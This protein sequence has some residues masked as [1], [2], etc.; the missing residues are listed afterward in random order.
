MRIILFHLRC[1]TE[2][3]RRLLPPR[4]INMTIG[5]VWC[6]KIWTTRSERHVRILLIQATDAEFRPKRTTTT[7]LRYT[8]HRYTWPWP[9]PTKQ[10]NSMLKIQKMHHLPTENIHFL[11][12][13]FWSSVEMRRKRPHWSEGKYLNRKRLAG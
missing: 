1:Q 6:V 11:N 3:T 10:T 5:H 8:T 4:S 13:C 2:Q 12:V 9:K 7:W